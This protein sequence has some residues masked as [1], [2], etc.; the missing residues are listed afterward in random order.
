MTALTIKKISK[1][2]KINKFPM[3][4]SPVLKSRTTPAPKKQRPIAPRYIPNLARSRSFK[5]IKNPSMNTSNPTPPTN[6]NLLI[7]TDQTS[8]SV[9]SVDIFN[10]VFV[11]NCGPYKHT[12]LI[13][14]NWFLPVFQ[15]KCTV[16]MYVQQYTV[17]SA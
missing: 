17:W 15:T 4:S 7:Q 6:P 1:P 14:K 10:T 9:F 12:G 13:P 3:I 16:H 8:P 5:A 2:A 11:F